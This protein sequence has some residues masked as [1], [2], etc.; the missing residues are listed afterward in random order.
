MVKGFLDILA[1]VICILSFIRLLTFSFIATLGCALHSLVVRKGHLPCYVLASYGYQSL[2][3]ID[4]IAW[5]RREADALELRIAGG[6]FRLSLWTRL[7]N[8]DPTCLLPSSDPI[9]LISGLAGLAYCTRFPISFVM[10]SSLHNL[11]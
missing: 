11:A 1:D 8:L 7:L 5:D 4:C 3:R 9:S 6:A 10:L 2:L